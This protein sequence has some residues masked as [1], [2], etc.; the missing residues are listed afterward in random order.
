MSCMIKKYSL[1]AL[2]IAINSAIKLDRQIPEK[3]QA[4]HGKVIELVI[5]PL[6]VR[7]FIQFSHH[8]MLLL[9]TYDAPVDTLIYSSP[10]GLIRLSLLPASKARSLFND[11]IR[12]SGD[13]ELGQQVKQIFDTLDI[14]WEGHLAHFTGDVIAHQIG[15]L[16]RKGVQFQKKFTHS[17]HENVTEYL[18]EELRVSPSQEELNDF[19]NEV[20]TLSLAVDRME[21]HINLL[22]NNNDA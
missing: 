17:M 2:Q 8:E 19:F 9:D 10:M 21:A 14:D 3:L 11:H 20:D 16:V 12:I 22:M 6:E 1:K 13:P 15:S 5:T 18:Q 7:F 4:L